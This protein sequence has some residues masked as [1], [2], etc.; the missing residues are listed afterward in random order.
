MQRYLGT[1]ASLGAALALGKH[2]WPTLCSNENLATLGLFYVSWRALSYVRD[3]DMARTLDII[4]LAAL[5]YGYW[6]NCF[7]RCLGLTVGFFT[8]H[9]LYHVPVVNA[10]DVS[11]ARRT[12][13]SIH[14]PGLL[15]SLRQD[16]VGYKLDL[17]Y[18][19][20]V[21]FREKVDGLLDTIERL[22]LL[23]CCNRV[24]AVA[25][26]RFNVA[27]ASKQDNSNA[28]SRSSAK[29]G[30]R[31]RHHI[32]R[33]ARAEADCYE[34]AAEA[35]RL[36]T[37]VMMASGE[38]NYGK[39]LEFLLLVATIYLVKGT[40]DAHSK[41]MSALGHRFRCAYAAF[42]VGVRDGRYESSRD[43]LVAVLEGRGEKYGGAV[44]KEFQDRFAAAPGG[45]VKVLAF[46]QSGSNPLPRDHP[47][48]HSRMVGRVCATVASFTEKT[49]R[50][51][52]YG[53]FAEHAIHAWF[54]LLLTLHFGIALPTA[55]A[56][57]LAARWEWGR[58][59][60][61][62]LT[63]HLLGKKKKKSVLTRRPSKRFE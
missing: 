36:M 27:D 2:W 42:A 40:S 8:I 31:T 15:D 37:Q 3:R 13:N 7:L 33:G 63:T 58:K 48:H 34:E 4:F 5:I 32:V 49:A 59:F 46:G 23:E 17:Y 14:F 47:E 26:N 56:R 10:A 1:L 24:M 29:L 45:V 22:L 16:S 61:Y 54:L 60:S 28:G 20:S 50:A 55:A 18:K 44:N 21:A 19:G 9:S 12:G 39:Q 6:T 43:A 35:D 30:A 62:T 53:R 11:E 41:I 52:G 57:L 38:S 25:T 51:S